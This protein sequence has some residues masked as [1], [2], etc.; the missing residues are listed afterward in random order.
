MGPFSAISDEQITKLS[1]TM[2]DD[3]RA[4]LSYFRGQISKMYDY[5]AFSAISVTLFLVPKWPY[6]T[7]FYFLILPPENNHYYFFLN[8]TLAALIEQNRL[9]ANRPLLI[10]LSRTLE[11][12]NFILL[13]QMHFLEEQEGPV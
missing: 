4:I 3:Y 12:Q 1:P 7:R 6:F 8:K 5:R 2:V 13:S 10:D 11:P 9:F